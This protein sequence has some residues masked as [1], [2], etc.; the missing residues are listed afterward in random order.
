MSDGRRAEGKYGVEGNS[1][2]LIPPL[3]SA[4]PCHGVERRGRCR[5]PQVWTPRFPDL[6][7][8]SIRVGEAIFAEDSQAQGGCARYGVP[9]QS[10]AL[11]YRKDVARL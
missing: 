11:Q 1:N 6:S 3:A 8:R 5:V 9:L 10:V 7:Q 2:S 4:Q